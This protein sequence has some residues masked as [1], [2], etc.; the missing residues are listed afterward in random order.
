VSD[1]ISAE[2]KEKAARLRLPFFYGWLLVGV[3]FV[4]MAIAVNARTAFS[5]FFPPILDEYG[6]DRGFTAGA[7]SFG[8]LISAIVMPCVGWLTDR[9]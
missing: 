2:G 3:S 5:L 6:W 4:S 9:A 1:S 7:F 8:F